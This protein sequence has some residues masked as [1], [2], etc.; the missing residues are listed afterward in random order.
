EPDPERLARL[1]DRRAEHSIGNEATAGFRPTAVVERGQLAV[2]GDG[3]EWVGE[4]CVTGERGEVVPRA[5][6]FE[7]CPPVDV[8]ESKHGGRP[9]T[10]SLPALH[11]SDVLVQ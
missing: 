9:Y 11:G 10:A 6:V 1:R 5:V 4:R 7:C 2:A 8:D 3:C